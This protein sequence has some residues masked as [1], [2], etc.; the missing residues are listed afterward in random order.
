MPPAIRHMGQE[1]LK[2]MS[3]LPNDYKPVVERPQPQLVLNDGNRMPML[4][5]GT[6]NAQGKE[7]K[8]A[9]KAAIYAGYRHIDTAT[10]YKNEHLVGEAISECIDEMIVKRED[11]FITTKLWNNSHSRASVMEAICK[12]L[13]ALKTN[14]V[15]LYLIHYPI[16][17]QEGEVLSPVDALGQVITSDVDYVETWLGMEDVKR[18]GLT[19][20]IGVSNFNIA[21]LKRILQNCSIVPTMNQVE[22]HPYLNQAKLL[23]FC[24]SQGIK[25]TAYSPLGSPGRLD[26]HLQEPYLIEDPLVKN[27]AKKYQRPPAH[28][29]IRYQLQRGIAVIPKAIQAAHIR[30][31]IDAL[32]FELSKDDMVKLESLNRNHRF[33]KFERC[34]THKYYPFNDEY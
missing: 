21:Q 2:L 10:N 27:I 33:M 28:V 11:M 20:S 8:D 30:S 15:D 12:S 6:W 31:N 5:L 29:L 9:V 34:L 7:L 16:G 32:T 1:D 13:V 19:K 26:P 23:K 3:N 17:Y 18:A 4:G 14:Y 24:C 22:C 25:L